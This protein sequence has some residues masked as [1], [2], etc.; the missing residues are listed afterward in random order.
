M[1]F[2]L[3]VALAGLLSNASA[4]SREADCCNGSVC[5]L[6]LPCCH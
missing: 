5:C 1:K 2:I 3:I 4:I 6:P